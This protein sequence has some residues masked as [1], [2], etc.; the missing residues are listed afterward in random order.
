MATDDPKREH[1]EPGISPRTAQRFAYDVM[2]A[3]RELGRIAGEIARAHDAE[4]HRLYGYDFC[5]PLPDGADSKKALQAARVRW[6]AALSGFRLPDVET[7]D[8]EFQSEDSARDEAAR[9][10]AAD[11]VA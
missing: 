8:A 3:A 1:I 10:R 7:I 5:R 9:K 4:L 2:G 11:E 6:D